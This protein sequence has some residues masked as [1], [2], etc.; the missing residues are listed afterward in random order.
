MK[1]EFPVTRTQNPKPKPTDENN[2]GFGHYFTDHMFI[3]DY[4][5]GIGWH[6]GRIVPYAPIP[7]D[8]ASCVLHYAQ[9]MFEGMKAY[10][11]PDGELQLFRPDMNAKRMARSADR[12]ALPVI[13][14]DLLVASVTQLLEVDKDW[15]PTAP[16][17]SMY[18]RPFVFGNEISFSAQAAYHYTYMVILAATGAYYANTEGKMGTSRIFVQDKYIRSAA[19]GTGFAK[20]GGNYG[21]AMRASVDAMQY[22]CKDVLWLDAAE[23]KYV[24]EIGTSNAFFR[25]GDEVITASLDSGTILPGVTR[26]SVIQLLKKWGVK[27]SERKLAIDDVLAAAT[28]RVQPPTDKGRRLKIYYMTHASTRPPTFVCFVNRAD[29]FHYSYQRYIENQIREVFGLEGTPVRF[30]IRER[31]G[32]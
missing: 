6:D 29:L 13:P 3:M 20:V 17:T 4:D 10:L 1:Y 11:R 12:M 31:E 27:V 19:G 25:I 26:D 30:V 28:A 14:E 7:I 21:G 32:K 8:P 2:L 24:E 15:M 5:A 23:H 22:H 18:I 16:G 9:M